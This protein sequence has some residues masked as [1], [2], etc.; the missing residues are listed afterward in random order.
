MMMLLI[1]NDGSNCDYG[2]DDEVNGSGC[3]LRCSALGG[4]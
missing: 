3:R 4:S 2:D 1:V